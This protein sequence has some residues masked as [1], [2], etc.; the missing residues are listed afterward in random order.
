[1]WEL[2]KEKN[3]SEGVSTYMRTATTSNRVHCALLRGWEIPQRVPTPD[4]QAEEILT[5]PL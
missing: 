1:M 3:G 5:I 4:Y 2:N